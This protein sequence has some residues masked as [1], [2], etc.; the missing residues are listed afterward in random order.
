MTTH[1]A[2][3]A[4]V[5]ALFAGP[6]LA[7]NAIIGNRIEP[8]FSL[9][10][11]GIHTSAREYVLLAVV[12]VLIPIGAFVAARPMLQRGPDGRRR[13]YLLNAVLATLLSAAFVTLVAG[14]GSEIYRCDVL[15]VPNCD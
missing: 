11:P 6:F 14:L 10:R 4:A 12:L 13:F 3:A 5:G 2:V 8:F 9:I 15:R 7:A 1:P